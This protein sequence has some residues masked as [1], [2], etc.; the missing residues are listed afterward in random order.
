MGRDFLAATLDLSSPLKPHCTQCLALLFADDLELPAD[1]LAFAWQRFV[2]RTRWF[3]VREPTWCLA[4][5]LEVREGL[6]GL[7]VLTDCFSTGKMG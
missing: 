7:R 1:G 6:W 4:G 3:E 2:C 5:L